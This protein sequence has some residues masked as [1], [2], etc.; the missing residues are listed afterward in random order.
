MRLI[1]SQYE[2]PEALVRV[3]GLQLFP[4]SSRT[5]AVTTPVDP[6]LIVLY[7]MGKQSN[8]QTLLGR[9]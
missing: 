5:S 9:G 2:L 1:F 3:N 6:D 7:L 8:Y 4:K